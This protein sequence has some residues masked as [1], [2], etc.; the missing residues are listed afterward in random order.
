M[1]PAGLDRLTTTMCRHC[2]AEQACV[3][4]NTVNSAS[5]LITNNQHPPHA[6]I[7]PAHL[8]LGNISGHFHA[9][10]LADMSSFQH[11]Q[12]SSGIIK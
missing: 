1:N 2:N 12:N 6:R 10:D 9:P 11:T 3:S 7:H 4:C 8:Y 5:V